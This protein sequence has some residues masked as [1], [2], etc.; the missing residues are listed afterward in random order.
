M[1]VEE[2]ALTGES[3]P[4]EKDALFQA[5]Q[6]C[7]V[8]D[9][10]NM[11]YMSTVVTYGRGTGIVTAVGMDTE[12]GKIAA[13]ID[14]APQELTPLQKRLG[15]LG[16]LLSIVAVVLCAALFAIAVIQKRDIAD[17]LLQRYR[18]P[19]QQCRKVFRLW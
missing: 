4:V 16:K 18:S 9:R 13:M 15:D 1:K 5:N 7:P 2:S 10:K 17:M 19:W 14:E 12:I 8:G 6:T 3:L 11:A